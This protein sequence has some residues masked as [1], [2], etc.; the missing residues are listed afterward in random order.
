MMATPIATKTTNAA[1]VSHPAPATTTVAKPALVVAS[2]TKRAPVKPPV[3]KPAP[4]PAAITTHLERTSSG[5]AT[6]TN[7]PQPAAAGASSDTVRA[8]YDSMARDFAAQAGGSHTLQFELVCETSSIT[9]AI[10]EAGSKVWFVSMSYHGRPCYRVFWGRFNSSA[11]AAAATSQFPAALGVKP[12]V[13]KIP[14]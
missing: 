11:E 7:S 5:G 8:R 1:A 4:A 6:I 13:V 9:R 2:N 10:S 12:V 3:T 14:R